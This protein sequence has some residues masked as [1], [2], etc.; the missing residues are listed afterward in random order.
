MSYQPN[1][2]ML[3]KSEEE[4][5]DVVVQPTLFS[6]EDKPIRE[7]PRHLGEIVQKPETLATNFSNLWN[8]LQYESGKTAN[9]MEDYNVF[10]PPIWIAASQ[11]V[12][13]HDR[14][15]V[16]NLRERML[17]YGARSL[18]N[19]E[20]LTLVMSTGAGT[21]NIL[22]R[23]QSL[24][25][26]HSFKE[27][28]QI[29]IGELLTKHRL[30][31]AKATQ[32][33]ALLEIARRLTIPST[34]NR[35]QIRSPADAANFVIPHMAFLDH[36]EMRVLLLDTKNCVVADIFLY[37][38]TVNSSVVRTAEV[39]RHAVARN[40]PG[41]IIFHNHPSG[42]TEPSQEDIAVTRVLIEAAKI[43]EIALVD[44]IIIGGYNFLSLKER[45]K[46]E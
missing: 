9:S 36:E 32:L 3:E 18:S 5:R 44:H 4:N 31:E 37:K 25:E 23:M 6:F 15:S 33:Q 46:W 34:E 26:N 28:L 8:T 22:D 20:L 21:E 24:F 1:F 42:S 41:I 13:A 39:F 40:C 38:G 11:G 29:D 7:Q 35:Y 30:G 45:L 19:G 12:E 2:S 10:Q 17:M 14:A 16:K 43:F 27:L